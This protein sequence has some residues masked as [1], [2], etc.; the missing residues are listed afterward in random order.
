M[1]LR[2]AHEI[3]RDFANSTLLIFDILPY[4]LLQEKHYLQASLRYIIN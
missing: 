3:S 2:I 1:I 4:K